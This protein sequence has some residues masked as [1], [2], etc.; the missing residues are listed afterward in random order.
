MSTTSTTTNSVISRDG[1]TIGYHQLGHG[2]GLVMVHGAMQSALSQLEL[3]QAL[4]DTF[5]V[6]LP[7]RRGRGLSGP[8]RDGYS[9]RPEIEDVAALLEAT[10]AHDVFGVSSGAIIGL[11]AALA[12]PAVHRVAAF[13]PPLLADREEARRLLERIDRQLDRGDLPATLVTA[14]KGAQM[15]SPLL[16]SLPSRLLVWMITQG[17]RK[18]EKQ[19]AEGQVPLQTLVPLLHH[20]FQLVADGSG[21]VDRYHAVQQRVLLLGGSRSPGYIRTS[22]RRLEQVLPLCERVELPGLRHSAT[23]NAERQGAPERVAPILRRFFD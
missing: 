18:E 11:D 5:T 23:S 22:L 13:E 15:E 21:P 17:I 4:A 10:G 8:N 3:A 16:R 12:L 6:Y 7:D 1:T 9:V 14:M 19:S 20:E 2:P